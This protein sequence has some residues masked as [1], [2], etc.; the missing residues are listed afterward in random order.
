M[1]NSFGYIRDQR[2][3]TPVS[4]RPVPEKNL[5]DD[6]ADN[7]EIISDSL[8]RVEKKLDLVLEKITIFLKSQDLVESDSISNSNSNLD[9][10][11]QPAVDRAEE[12]TPAPATDAGSPSDYTLSA[13]QR[14]ELQSLLLS[15]PQEET[16]DRGN[17]VET[18]N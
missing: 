3:E 9:S 15:V 8:M 7:T 12:Q 2:R 5:S 17:E 1:S 10:D 11:S 14:N 16:K 6:V 13:E 4:V 18:D